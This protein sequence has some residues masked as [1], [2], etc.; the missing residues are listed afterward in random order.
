MLLLI[1]VARLLGEAALG[2]YA[3][4]IAITAIFVPILDVGLNTRVIRSVAA[5]N[6]TEALQDAFAFKLRFGPIALFLM[7]ACAWWADKP[8]DVVLAVFLVGVS[9]WAMSVGD[10][11]NAVFKGV[12]RAGYSALL[13]GGTYICLTGLGIGAMIYGAGILGIAVAYTLCRLG[14]MVA[15]WVL[16]RRLGYEIGKMFR[17]QAVWAG[18]YFMPAV[19][20]VG[21]LL[22]INFLTADGLGAGAESGVYAIGYRVA[23]ALFVLVSASLE[24]VLPA[25]V[26]VGDNKAAFRQLF[27][28]CCGVFLAG[29]ILAVILVQLLGFWAVVWVFGTD[30]IGAVVAVKV[31]GW[32]L[33]ALLICAAGHTA[34]LALGR[35]REGF[36]WMVCL[37]GVGTF[38]GWLG[39]GWAG[40]MG[41][42]Y[43]PAVTGCLFAC[44]LGW[45]V[46]LAMNKK[47]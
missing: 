35:E 6:G 25:L 4:I 45:R 22:N 46:K 34:M 44:V 18:V 11:F 9:T 23:A 3:Y 27:F 28:R 42:A 8:A 10:A 38:L 13:V 12:Q 19:F 30:Y 40:A 14:F 7:I 16:I 5:G 17:W 43:A 33:P 47:K 26:G 29:G 20:F 21:I 39:F 41:T 36:V 15:A 37:V 32:I 1:A 2:T 31:L 24:G